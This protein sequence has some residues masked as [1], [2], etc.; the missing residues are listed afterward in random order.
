MPANKV[1]TVR[2]RSGVRVPKVG[3]GTSPLKGAECERAVISALE[4]GYRLIDTA[5]NYRNE[6]AVGAA[7]RRSGIPRNEVVITTKFNREWHSIDGV[8]EVLSRSLELLGFDYVDI[9]LI[10]WPN[11]DQDRYVDAFEGMLAVQDEGLTHAIG[12]SNFLP[13]HLEK[14]AQN[15]YIPEINQIQL[16][17]LRPRRDVLTYMTANEIRG[18]CWSPL[19]AGKTDLLERPE[20]KMIAGLHDVTVGQVVLRW[21]V[22]QALVTIPKSAS[23]ERQRDNLDIFGFELSR[24]EMRLIDTLEDPDAPVSDPEIFGH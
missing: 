13:R 17:P 22:Q 23:P 3:L 5:E 19:G 12:T 24:A 6:D 9:L 18:E 10:H 15:G 16:D 21:Q 20:L 1:P 2:L 7:V 4:L 14:L 8:R 11:P